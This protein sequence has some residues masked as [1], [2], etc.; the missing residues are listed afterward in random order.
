MNIMKKDLPGAAVL[1]L[2]GLVI[3]MAVLYSCSPKP[4]A[5]PVEKPYVASAAPAIEQDILFQINRHRQANHL[6][7]LIENSVIAQEA[8]KHSIDMASHMV[9]FGHDGLNT[10]MKNISGKV[11]GVSQVGENVAW[12][13]L[14]AQQVVSAWLNSPGHRRNIEG[15]YRLTGLIGLNMTY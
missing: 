15:K 1:Y 3:M 4:P 9:S 10:R 5:K 7:P 13:N 11:S 12:G 2:T 6:P 14:N 8:R